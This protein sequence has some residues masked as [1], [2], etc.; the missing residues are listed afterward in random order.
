MGSMSFW[1]STNVD[2]GLYRVSE[3][4]GYAAVIHAQT[5]SEKLLRDF[6]LTFRL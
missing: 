2:R 6:T 4:C 1:L 3:E 5:Y